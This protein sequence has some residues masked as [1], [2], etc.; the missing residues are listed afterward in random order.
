MFKYLAQARVI[1]H[2]YYLNVYYQNLLIHIVNFIVSNIHAQTN[3]CFIIMYKFISI[4]VLFH[5]LIHMHAI[6]TF[7]SSE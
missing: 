7:V 1:V 2:A 3:H 4:N 5:D 6:D